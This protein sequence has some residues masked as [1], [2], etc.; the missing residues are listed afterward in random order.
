MS[1]GRVRRTDDRWTASLRRL[2][3]EAV[4]APTAGLR[5]PVA[6][7]RDKARLWRDTA[8]V[9]V[10]MESGFAA[11]VAEERGLPF[12]ALR[13]V[14]DPAGRSVPAAA[15]QGVRRDGSTDAA[16]VMLA[17]MR[18]AGADPGA[19]R[20]RARRGRRP[21]RPS[22]PARLARAAASASSISAS[23]RSTWREKRYS[24]G[25]W[26]SSGISGAI[27]PSVL[28]PRSATR[29]GLQRVLHRVHHRRRLVAAS[30]PCSRRTSRSCRCRR[31]PSRSPPSAP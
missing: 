28:T 12:A 11:A 30:G 17:L 18:R 4:V 25:R 20:A 21:A 1:D 19:D 8:A 27:G 15:L 16:A 9:T 29:S 14:A 10:D 22:S 13:V 7:R 26:F 31:R 23:L 3:P 24:A 5:E 2:V 6:G